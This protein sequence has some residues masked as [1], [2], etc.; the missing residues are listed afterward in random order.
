MWNKV[1]WKT[2]LL[3]GGDKLSIRRNGE[4]WDRVEIFNFSSEIIGE[5]ENKLKVICIACRLHISNP[6]RNVSSFRS[7]SCRRVRDSS[8]SAAICEISASGIFPTSVGVNM[9]H[10]SPTRS[11]SI[12]WMATLSMK[13]SRAT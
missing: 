10:K 13:P 4:I 12:T 5:G 3:V 2:K 6:F 9:T 1:L 11:R 8:D 7:S